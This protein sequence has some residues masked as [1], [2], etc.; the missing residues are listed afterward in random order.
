MGGRIDLDPCANEH[1]FV[2]AINEFRLPQKDGLKTKWFGGNIFVNPPYGRDNGSTI[3]DWLV[4][5]RDVPDSEVIYL[6]PVATNTR[7]FKEIVFKEAAAI[8]FLSD[9]RLKFWS[10][11]TEDKKG[12]PMACC[13][14]YFGSRTDKFNEFFT[15]SGKVFKIN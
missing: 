6:I 7:H 10:E 1:G 8:C 13:L 9:T 2:N 14:V 11:G 4:K 5:H 12:A 15:K 3:Y